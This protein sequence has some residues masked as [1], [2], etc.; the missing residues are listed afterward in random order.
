M[1]VK[2]AVVWQAGGTTYAT[3]V[4]S[5]QGTAGQVAEI[6]ATEGAEIITVAEVVNV[7]QARQI[8]RDQAGLLINVLI[9][10]EEPPA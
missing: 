3:V 10:A 8:R 2:Q 1:A 9:D 5:G 7:E 4:F 6:E